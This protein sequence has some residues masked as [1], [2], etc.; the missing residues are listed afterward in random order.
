MDARARQILAT[1]SIEVITLGGNAAVGA[2][3]VTTGDPE[4]TIGEIQSIIQG[5]N[6]VYTK[7]NPGVP[8]AYTVRYLKDNALAKMGY[9]T[10]YTAAECT[11]VQTRNT[12][13]VTLDQFYVWRDCDS[14]GGRGD[15]EFTAQVNGGPSPLTVTRATKLGRESRSLIRQNTSLELPREQGQWFRVDFWSSEWDVTAFGR[16]FRD[17]DMDNV[18]GLVIHRFEGGAWTSTGGEDDGVIRIRNGGG[19]CQ[20]ELWYTVSIQ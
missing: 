6:A 5:E 20:A 10:D 14:A 17:A 16:R 15:F 11:A 19:N 8:I 4:A 12:I 7:S 2:R 18:H 13:T 9:T 1:S 3:A